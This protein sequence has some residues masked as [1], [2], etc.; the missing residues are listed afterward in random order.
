ML[1]FLDGACIDEEVVERYAGDVWLDI[2][3]WIVAGLMR[4]APMQPL[5][6]L[7]HHCSRLPD[8]VEA[9]QGHLGMFRQLQQA[10]K[11]PDGRGLVDA[12]TH[13]DDQPPR[14]KVRTV[15]RRLR[16]SNFTI[17]DVSPIVGEVSLELPLDCPDAVVEGHPLFTGHGPNRVE[18]E[19]VDH[20]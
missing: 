3:F 16:I 2:P 19:T 14:R 8:S 9:F 12:P 5:D 20:C 4:V 6:V 10:I 13:I 15:Q 17:G 1:L 18:N 7:W 11:L